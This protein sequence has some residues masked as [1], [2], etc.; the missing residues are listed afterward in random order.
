MRCVI[1]RFCSVFVL[2]WLAL[3][4]GQGWFRFGPLVLEGVVL[5]LLMFII[6]IMI[7]NIKSSK[8]KN[9]N[10]QIK[11]ELF[12]Y[13]YFRCHELYPDV[14]HNEN[15]LHQLLSFTITVISML[16]HLPQKHIRAT[17]IFVLFVFFFQFARFKVSV[18]YALQSNSAIS[19]FGVYASK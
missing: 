4:V 19:Q 3:S 14:E 15:E 18:D 2:P 7:T 17:L 6:I 1:E 12:F 16:M 5:L 8:G 11:P 13:Y 9:V 10:T